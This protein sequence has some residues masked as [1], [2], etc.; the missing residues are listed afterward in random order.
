[1]KKKWTLVT[2]AAG[3]LGATVVRQLVENGVPVKAF[4]R[5]G[6]NLKVLENLP[7]DLCTLAYGDVTIEASVYRALI[8]CDRLFHVAST[9]K[10]GRQHQRD[11]LR[12]AELGTQAVL[13]AAK[14]HEL[15]RIVVTSSTAV[16]GVS[17][18]DQLLDESSENQL[19]D[20]EPYVR[21]KI[22][23]DRVVQE[24]VKAGMPIISV[25]PGA[26]FGPGDWKP[27]HNGQGLLH[28]VKTPPNRKTPTTDGG[29]SFVDVEDVARGH[30][31]AM[32]KGRVGERYIL[33]GENLTYRDFFTLLHELT[34]LSEPGPTPSPGLLQ[35]VARFMEFSA[36]WAGR[37]PLLT[38][39]LA[40]DYAYSRVWVSS[41]KAER[42]LGY[43]F[44][45]ARETLARS[46][47]FYLTQGFI[48]QPLAN[49]LRLE[50]RPV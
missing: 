47:R 10:Y 38:Y 16:L 21:A 49:R 39:R 11:V 7:R 25:L 20:P 37:D 46:L 34:G 44:R 2:G 19:Q 30:L 12:S 50:L 36:R 45:P 40:R 28:Y 17:Q 18:G 26:I 5:P 29:N 22:A 41:A 33:G 6:A 31:L 4:V 32:A 48:E 43:S 13:A 24:H 8:G 9:Y 1:M 27:T 14:Q 23:A 3:F 42:E 35:L 15:P